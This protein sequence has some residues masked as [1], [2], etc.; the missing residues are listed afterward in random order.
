MDTYK[1]TLNDKEYY[2]L[3]DQYE[4][5]K[6]LFKNGRFSE[7][8]KSKENFRF[9]TLDLNVVESKSEFDYSSITDLK[10]FIARYRE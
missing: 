3:V 9:K 1:K 2:N 10:T 6:K 5:V 7:K 8:N 4:Y